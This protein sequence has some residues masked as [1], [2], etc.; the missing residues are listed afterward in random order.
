MGGCVDYDNLAWG[1][2]LHWAAFGH[3]G[4]HDGPTGEAFTHSDE[5]IVDYAARG[6]HV[7]TRVAK[8][9]VRAYYGRPQDRT[10]YLGCSNGGRQGLRNAQDNPEDFDGILA[11]APAVNFIPLL[12]Q[13]NI[14]NEASHTL[15]VTGWISVSSPSPSRTSLYISSHSS[16]SERR[17]SVVSHL[18]H[19]VS[20]SLTLENSTESATP[21]PFPSASSIPHLLQDPALPDYYSRITAGAT[22]CVP[23]SFCP[24]RTGAEFGLPVQL[25]PSGTSTWYYQMVQRALSL[26]PSKMDD[27]YR[28]FLV[29]GMNHCF[30]GPG[31]WMIGQAV[32]GVWSNSSD[33]NALLALVDWVEKGKGPETLRG[34]TD[35]TVNS[36]TPST[37]LHCKYP[38]RSVWKPESN[39]WVCE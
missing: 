36:T 25:I 6:L 20:S 26:P 7:A 24:S 13:G 28:L 17:L 2:A 34:S 11:G 15:G 29:P 23:S 31:A 5:I 3:D 16:A 30:S 4:G 19:I 18:P 22:S 27:F 32:F 14:A 12:A 10:Y 33:A 39:D 21:R 37:R 9:L 35:G 8:Q 38:A 1:P